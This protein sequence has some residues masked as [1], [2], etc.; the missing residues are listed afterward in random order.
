[1]K[2][3]PSLKTWSQGSH[4]QS[5]LQSMLRVVPSLPPCPLGLVLDLIVQSCLGWNFQPTSLGPF[6]TASLPSWLSRELTAA[7]RFRDK[8]EENK[9]NQT[10]G[11]NILC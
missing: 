6:E 3:N 2:V 9:I 8:Y 1:M 11:T 10:Q 5:R 4:E 7:E